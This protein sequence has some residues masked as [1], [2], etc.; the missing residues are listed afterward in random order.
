MEIYMKKIRITALFVLIAIMLSSCDVTVK[1]PSISSVVGGSQT[2]GG[3]NIVGGESGGGEDESSPSGPLVNAEVTFDIGEAVFV[4]LPTGENV[5]TSGIDA[6]IGMAIGPPGAR[7]MTDDQPKRDNELTIGRCNRE[8]SK[9]G[10][11]KLESEERANDNIARYG[12]Y[13]TGNSIA[14][15][16]DSVHGYDQF[17]VNCAVRLFEDSYVQT[18]KPINVPAGVFCSGSVDILAYQ[19]EIDEPLI[20]SSWASFE[21]TAGKEA[22]EALKEMYSELYSEKLITWFASL[23]DTEIGGFYYSAS[24]RDNEK[25]YYNG[26]YYHLLPDIEST[27]QAINFMQNSGM[28]YGITELTGA[29]PEWMQEDLI[30]F[31]KQRQSPNGYFYHPQWPEAKASISRRGRDLTNA[32]ALLRKL[33]AYPTY[34]TPSGQFGDGILWDGTPVSAVRLTLPLDTSSVSAVSFVV[35]TATAVPSHLVDKASFEQYLNR[36]NVRNNSYS[37]GNELASQTS[38][39]KSRDKYLKSQGADYSL[40]DMLINYLDTN[41]YS[42]TGHWRSV[43]DYAGINGLMKI[44]SVYEA[45]DAPLPY[46]EAAARS[47][48]DSITK[49]DVSSSTVCYVYNSWVSISNI[50]SNV[51]QYGGKDADEIVATIRGELREN[52]AA[53]IMATA[54]KQGSFICSDGSFS[55]HKTKTSATSQGMPVAIAGTK[56][57]DVNATAICTT[58]T[59]KNMIKAFGFPS[60]PLFTRSDLLTFISLVSKNR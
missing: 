5:P 49:A 23:Y 43:S 36:L 26:A 3:S 60:V 16:Y 41:C 38:E 2:G 51:E 50:I 14:I 22:T 53:L 47:A 33:G 7:Y 10:Y 19:R 48:I 11:E 46:P 1:V 45:L 56:E 35:A 15:V 9:L 42:T 31:I 13:S 24:A 55:Y 17:I 4:V 44:S 18:D 40:V 12:F 52:A 21:E 59:V 28:T 8:V 32:V 29:L 58:G 6:T 20:E 37:V 30:R 25:V 27:A 57:G 39:I 34:K 54:A